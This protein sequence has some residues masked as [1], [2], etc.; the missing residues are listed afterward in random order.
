M[1]RRLIVMTSIGLGLMSVPSLPALGLEIGAQGTCSDTVTKSSA[2][3]QGAF[4][5]GG[6]GV[7][8]SITVSGFPGINTAE[9]EGFTN[10]SEV[11]LSVVGPGG[12]VGFIKGP[13]GEN[14]VGGAYT[15][16]NSAGNNSR[17]W[18]RFPSRSLLCIPRRCVG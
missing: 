3:W 10:G 16:G 6:T 11:D 12:V 15:L 13:I 1:T 4:H 17:P 9:V 2:A 14:G 8:G 7:T 18:N 5:V